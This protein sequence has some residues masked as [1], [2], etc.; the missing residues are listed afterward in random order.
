MAS[1][2]SIDFFT[3]IFFHFIPALI[4]LPCLRPASYFYL[5]ILKFGSLN[6]KFND[7]IIGHFLEIHDGKTQY[8]FVTV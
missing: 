4:I 3:G 2:N 6:F 8:I 1:S 5:K 7:D